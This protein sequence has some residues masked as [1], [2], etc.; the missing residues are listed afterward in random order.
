MFINYNND[1]STGTDDPFEGN[2]SQ[3]GMKI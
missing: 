1:N 3:K 2:N